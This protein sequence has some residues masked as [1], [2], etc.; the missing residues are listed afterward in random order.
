MVLRDTTNGTEELKS[1]AKFMKSM[2]KAEK[3][4]QKTFSDG[5]P[6]KNSNQCPLSSNKKQNT[7]APFGGTHKKNMCTKETCQDKQPNE[8]VNC[9]YNSNGKNYQTELAQE[10]GGGWGYQGGRVYQGQGRGGGCGYHNVRGGCGPGCRNYQGT[11]GN[12]GGS[13]NQGNNNDVQNNNG[14]NGNNGN[15]GQNYNGDPPGN[16]GNNKYQGSN[17]DSNQGSNQGPNSSNGN[18]GNPN[19]RSGGNNQHHFD[20]IGG[21]QGNNQEGN[22]N[23]RLMNLW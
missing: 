11:S 16:N 4:T 12:Q 23:D 2:Y 21:N 13:N 1:V 10:C 18:Q 20:M 22:Q 14:N 15:D 19:Q 17:Q 9:Y 5:A 7:R 8:W 6:L 3:V